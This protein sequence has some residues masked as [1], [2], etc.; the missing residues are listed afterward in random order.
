MGM[1]MGWSMGRDHSGMSS[2]ER[3]MWQ[4]RM[5][6]D[7]MDEQRMRQRGGD[8]SESE[9]EGGMWSGGEDGAMPMDY[10]T[11]MARWSGHGEVGQAGAVSQ[12]PRMWATMMILH[13]KKNNKLTFADIAKEVGRDE[14]W[15]TSVIMGQNSM[16]SKEAEKL[17]RV[18]G[19]KDRKFGNRICELLQEAPLRGGA[20]GSGSLAGLFGGGN[21]APSDPTIYRFHEVIN[22]YG[23]TFK[24]L[25]HE[26]FG[27]GAVDSVGM[28]VHL[29]PAQAME[30]SDGSGQ[31]PTYWSG[32]HGSGSGS[33]S[34]NNGMRNGDEQRV[35]VVLEGTFIPYRPW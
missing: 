6:R 35:Q 9:S 17:C 4:Q 21:G 2:R 5:Q 15:V 30:G 27:D 14:F 28:K 10:D 19:L 16:T 11:W 1:G 13:C 22:V 34:H 26:K 31:S 24:A 3:Q 29:R 20:L 23:S 32:R 12:L 8:M 25:I 18:V 7:G 33:G